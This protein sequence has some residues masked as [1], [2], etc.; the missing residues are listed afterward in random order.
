MVDAAPV[1]THESRS[2]DVF[3]L[4]YPSIVET[5][6]YKIFYKEFCERTVIYFEIEPEDITILHGAGDQS[7]YLG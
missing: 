5:V 2:L 1:S 6:N 7:Q 3:L 4:D